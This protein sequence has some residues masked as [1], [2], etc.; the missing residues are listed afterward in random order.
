MTDMDILWM[1]LS[2]VGVLG[3]FFIMV[4]AMKK[5][6]KGIG[7]VDG[8]RMKVIDRVTVGKDV[9]LL[10]VSVAGR[11]LLIG[12]SS[13]TIEMLGELNMTAEEYCE[14]QLGG[15]ENGFASV[16]AEMLKR[17]KGD[18]KD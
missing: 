12:A 2:L 5:L 6:G 18:K 14:G 1:I 17:N 13:Q 3:L 4:Y 9:M 8:N 16:L 15:N 11:L 7:F 10:V